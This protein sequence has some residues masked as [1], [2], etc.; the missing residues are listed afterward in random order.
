M[1]AAENDMERESTQQVSQLPFLIIIGWA[2]NDVYGEHE[3]I[4]RQWAQQPKYRKTG[5]SAK[6]PMSGQRGRS[7]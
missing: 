2:G 1:I 7:T 6:L 3:Y 4:N 5:K